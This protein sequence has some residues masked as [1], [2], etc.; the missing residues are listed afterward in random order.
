MTV[1]FLI[2]YT[3]DELEVQ[4]DRIIETMG[5]FKFEDDVWC[6]EKLRRNPI[7]KASDYTV[8]FTLI[9]SDY[10][11]ILKRYVLSVHENGEKIQSTIRTVTHIK[12]FIKFLEENNIKIKDINKNV[13][14]E[15]KKYLEAYDMKSKNGV[16]IALK[17]FFDSISQMKDY[18]RINYFK[19]K[20]P[21]P[22]KVLRYDEKY[23]PKTIIKQMDKVFKSEEIDLEIRVVYWICRSIPSRIGEVL[24]TKIDCIKN[25]NGNTKVLLLP[26]WK[27]GKAEEA[28]I[29]KVYFEYIG[30][31]KF[32]NDLIN[33]QIEVAKSLQNKLIEEERGYLLSK[34][35]KKRM[36]K[37]KIKYENE[38]PTLL[39]Y[40]SVRRTFNRILKENKVVDEN[41]D[42]YKFTSHQ[43]RHNGITDRLYSGFSIAQVS[44]I[45]A[46]KSMKMIEVAY[47]HPEKEVILNK[48]RKVQSTEEK[49]YFRGKILNLDE[50]REKMLLQNIRAK[51]IEKL[52]ICSDFTDCKSYQCLACEYLIPEVELL[53]YYKEQIGELERKLLR[54]GDSKFLKENIE[55][56]IYL[57]KTIIA[58]IERAL[59]SVGEK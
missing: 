25:F 6:C 59:A 27:Q 53:P 29:R 31:G 22:R 35:I 50:R 17:K 20:N 37:S 26:T 42:I 11:N 34:T 5:E 1:K 47:N 16:W 44:Y 38:K 13:V 19:G 24:G 18:P 56:N 28:E 57:Y 36:K 45:T 14:F 39:R 8:Y 52:G 58:K 3:E 49:T 46:H 4:K 33:E 10:K 30:H 7:E 32:L 54:V 15:F 55:Y 2:R 21:F 9:G 12:V 40:D 48:Q 43:L 23:V 51:R 41:G